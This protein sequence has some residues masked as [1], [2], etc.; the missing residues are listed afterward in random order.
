MMSGGGGAASG[1]SAPTR[2]NAK[3]ASDL[4]D[5]NYTEEQSMVKDAIA[6]FALQIRESAE[7]TD[8]KFVVSDE[9]KKGFD[10]LG[11]VFYQVPESLGGMMKEKSTVTQMMAVET[12]AHGDLGQALAL[13]TPLSVLNALVEW[14][15]EAQQKELIPQFLE[16]SIP[17]AS[18]ALNEP[19][20]LF[21]PYELATKAEKTANGYKIT[22]VKNMV[23]LGPTAKFFI[24]IAE[25]AGKGPQAFIVD[26]AAKGLTITEDRGMGL[27]AAQLS[28]LTLAGVEV[29]A[30]KLLGAGDAFNYEEYLNYCKLGWCS[31]AVGCC[32]AVLDYVIPY[33]NDRV[34]FG[35]PISHR[36]A[37]AFI[38][39]DMKIELDAMR[40][41]TQRAVARAEQGL[42]FAKEA[43]LAHILCSDK[44]MIIGSN[45]VQLLGGH[46][47][48]RDFPVQRW[49]RD[50]RAVAI[51][52]NGV[53]L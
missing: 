33:A 18:M 3:A 20:V 51:A 21:S 42:T 8:E 43:Y 45:G 14:G 32:Q 41:L 2:L 17:A 16:A 24:V 38:I 31:L 30:S 11:L 15:T 49:Y 22:G 1:G 12:L 19:S 13:Y 34:A 26:R 9:I 52:V 37:V 44:S 39:A 23:P 47:Y 46:G 48:I 4:F 50:L 40:I 35:E 10:E 29:D 6:Q 25:V 36:Q 28:Q 53:H 5:L 27:N 7:K